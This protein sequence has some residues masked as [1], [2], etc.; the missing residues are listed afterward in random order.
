MDILKKYE[1][2]WVSKY[3]KNFIVVI[4]FN[5]KLSYYVI[6]TFTIQEH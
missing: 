4:N 3:G 1:Q 5:S 6:L 2:K